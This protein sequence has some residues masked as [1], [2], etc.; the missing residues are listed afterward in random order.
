MT[1]CPG[2]VAPSFNAG[3]YWSLACRMQIEPSV[4]PCTKLKV[5]W[6]KKLHIKPESMKLTE[7]RLG[8]RVE[9]MVTR[10]IFLNRTTIAYGVR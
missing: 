8:K 1:I 4:S 5:K 3:E 10:E 6:T 7:K 2:L 9:H